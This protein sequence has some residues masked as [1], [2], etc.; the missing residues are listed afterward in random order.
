MP[1][2]LLLCLVLLLAT[3]CTSSLFPKTSPLEEVVLSGEGRDKVLLVEISG[4]LTSAKPGGLL[5]RFFDRLSLPARFKEELAKAEDDEDVKAIVLRINTPGGTVTA[6]DILYHEIKELKK[7]REIPVIASI[8]DLGTSGGYY[9]A[10][11]AD[12]IVAHPSSVTGSLGVIMLTLNASG[13]MEKIGV[14]ANAVTSGPHKDMGSP[15]RSMTEQDRA[16][17]QGVIDNFYDRFLRVIEQGRPN[18]KSDTIR[19]LAD[20]RIYSATQAKD[21]GLVDVIGYVDDALELAK[22]KAGIEEAQVI[23]YQR[24]GGY[25]PNIYAQGPGGLA[26]TDWAFPKLDPVSLL[27]TGGTPAFMYLWL[28]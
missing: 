23:M 8:M 22:K 3:G 14:R 4:V 21:H 16:I 10:M 15:F 12:R 25:H 28:P 18:L 20:G 1:K 11:A 2:F 27:L 17:F 13:L 6:S 9:V 5:D 19:Q 26:R 7:T 24:S